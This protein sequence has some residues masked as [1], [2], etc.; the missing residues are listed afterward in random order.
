MND[1]IPKNLKL[2]IITTLGVRYE[3]TFVHIIKEEKSILLKNVKNYGTENRASALFIPPVEKIWDSIVFRAN[4]ISTIASDELP[5]S[6]E[7]LPKNMI[8]AC[9]T[10]IQE[11]SFFIEVQPEIQGVKNP[12]ELS[13]KSC[14]N[15]LEF[16]DTLSSS[17]TS[18]HSHRREGVIDRV[19]YETFGSLPRRGMFNG[20]GRQAPQRIIRTPNSK[21]PNFYYVAKNQPS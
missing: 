13:E 8:P 12:K 6:S 18:G 11:E 4:E 20:R 9:S 14:Y 5:L 16:F 3:G 1:Q 17:V 15:K 10:D 2:Q 19:N 21:E 7:F